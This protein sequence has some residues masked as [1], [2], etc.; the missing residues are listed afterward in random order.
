MSRFEN[1]EFGDQSGERESSKP[2][3]RDE[4]FYFGQAEEAFH[5]GLFEPALRHYSR[6]IEFNPQNAQAWTK[7]VRMLIELGEFKEA[8]LWAEKALELFP[9]EP[10]LLAAK[11]VAL[12][13]LGDLDGALSFCDA[14]VESSGHTPYV[15]LARADVLLARKEKRAEYCFEKAFTLAANNWLILWLAARIQAFYQHFALGLKLARQALA[16]EPDRAVLW[17]EVGRC[18]LALGLPVQAQR[19]F[20]QAHELD[21]ECDTS[22]LS[23]EA[24][25]TGLLDKVLRRWRQWW[26]K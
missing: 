14:A 10:E 12:G 25:E 11:G 20:E 4:Q 5:R 17:L 22:A 3:L 26:Q 24:A 6:V 21:S 16:L 8:R 19:A 15:W 2:A 18:E 1:L 23:R 13:R 9:N 7:Q